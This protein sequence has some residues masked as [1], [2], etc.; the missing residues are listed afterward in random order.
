MW[1]AWRSVLLLIHHLEGFA[2]RSSTRGEVVAELSSPG[3]QLVPAP[4]LH[5]KMFMPGPGL[6]NPEFWDERVHLGV[7]LNYH[8]VGV[9]VIGV[10]TTD[11]VAPPSEPSRP[12][13][14][15]RLSSRWLTFKRSA[16]ASIAHSGLI[17][18]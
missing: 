3:I 16:D 18:G 15:T 9:V 14:G 17:N 10:G 7:E 11:E 6:E 5:R 8:L 4:G 2:W 12:I 13:S 1:Q